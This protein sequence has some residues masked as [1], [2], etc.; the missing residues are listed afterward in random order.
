MSVAAFDLASLLPALR[1][2]RPLG[3][4]FKL[5]ARQKIVRAI[6]ELRGQGAIG[7]GAGYPEKRAAFEALVI[8]L[9]AQGVDGPDLIDWLNEGLERA[10]APRRGA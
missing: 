9:R 2:D 6:A 7:D 3:P 8:E 5:G 1:T 4:D 10:N